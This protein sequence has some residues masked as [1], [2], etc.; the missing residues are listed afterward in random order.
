MYYLIEYAYIFLEIVSDDVLISVGC[1]DMYPVA[2][3]CLLLT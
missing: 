1:D 3:S 2:F